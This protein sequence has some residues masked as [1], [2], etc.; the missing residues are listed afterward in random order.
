MRVY[1]ATKADNYKDAR[2]VMSL[3]ESAGHEITY[4]WTKDVEELGPGTLESDPAK[5]HEL[6]LKDLKGVME[7][8][9]LIVIPKPGSW[10]HPIEMG[11]A[12]AMATPVILIG[13]TPYYTI[14]QELSIVHHFSVSQAGKAVRFLNQ[15]E[16]E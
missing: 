15:L 7:A 2:Y 14:F 16:E 9:A 6:A 5:M 13:G 3:C 4:D 8:G 10:G 12:L 1:V 11:M